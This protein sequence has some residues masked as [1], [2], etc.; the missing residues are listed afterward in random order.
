VFPAEGGDLRRTGSSFRKVHA[1]VRFGSLPGKPRWGRPSVLRRLSWMVVLVTGLGGLAPW[2]AERPLQSIRFVQLGDGAIEI[3]VEKALFTVWRPGGI[4][5]QV[6]LTR[7]ILWPVISSGGSPV[8]RCW[9]LGT[10]GRDEPKDHA[11]HQGIWLAYG[12]LLLGERDTLDTWAVYRPLPGGPE[13]P[14]RYRPGER[15]IVTCEQTTADE[16]RAEIRARCRWQTE[17]DGLQFLIEERRMRF[18]AGKD[19]RGIDFV[20]RLLALD[21]PV[22]FLDSKEGFF[23]LRVGPDLA[24]ASAES[25][26]AQKPAGYFGPG[27]AS[28]E[29]QIW[30]R[31]FPWVALRGTLASGEPMTIIFMDHPDNVNHPSPWMTRAYGLFAV[32]PFGTGEFAEGKDRFHFRLPAGGTVTLK[33]RILLCSRHL[34]AEEV[35]SLY[36]RYCEGTSGHAEIGSW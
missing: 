34:A 31:R 28:G 29:A 2:A 30:G 16:K 26:S 32:N 33:Y 17:R 23:G 1:S 25:P 19:W 36:Q 15:G 18:A 35:E 9:P 24:E 8:T 10:C 21:L 6:R 11:H 3:R 14:T 22:E 7:P 5:N 20:I 12:R 27:G 13:S 4:V